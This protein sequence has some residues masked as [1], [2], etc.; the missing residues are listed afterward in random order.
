MNNNIQNKPFVSG[1]PLAKWII[2]LIVVDIV[3]AV[4]AIPTTYYHIELLS[5]TIAGEITTEA[6][7]FAVSWWEEFMGLERQTITEDLSGGRLQV[8]IT[9]LYMLKFITIAALLIIS[10]MWLYRVHKNLPALGVSDLRFSPGWAVASWLIPIVNFY[11]PYQVVKEIWKASD[12][13]VNPSS[14]LSWQKTPTSL[15]LGWWWGFWLTS[16]LAGQASMF[17]SKKTLGDVY[18]MSWVL[19]ASDILIIVADIF[20]ILIV[21]TIDARQEAK[22]RRIATL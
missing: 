12:P 9:I 16:A 7:I 17:L 1:H 5:K 21:R 15:I 3:L 8:I 10:L 4:V 6:E 11:L 22:N 13:S 2:F 20:L 14:N 18:T 19:L